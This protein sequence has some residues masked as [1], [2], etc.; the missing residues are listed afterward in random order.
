MDVSPD[1]P[2]PEGDAPAA[3]PGDPPLPPAP[4][5]ATEVTF[6]PSGTMRVVTWA[7]LGLFLA[8]TV[9]FVACAALGA[10]KFLATPLG[11]GI[12]LTPLLAVVS[13]IAGAVSRRV[14]KSLRLEGADLVLEREGSERRVPVASLAEG[15]LSPHEKRV[16]LQD[17]R[18]DV[19]SAA[20]KDDAAG[21]ALLEAAG[22]DA[23]KRTWRTRLGPVDFLTAMSWLVGP[24]VVVPLSEL[25]ATAFHTDRNLGLPL[26]PFLFILQFYLVRAVFGPAH[27]VVGADG[28]IVKQR[29]RKR[30]VPFGELDHITTEVNN[31]TLHLTDGTAIRARARNL[32]DEAR[33]TI[34]ERVGA[35]L[36]LRGGRA[37]EPGA[38]AELDRGARTAAEWRAAL[39]GLLSSDRGYRAAR[40]TRE[41]VLGVLENPAAPA[42]RR[43]GAALALARSA[44]P[45]ADADSTARTRIAASASANERVRVAL[46]KIAAGQLDDAAIDEAAEE[47]EARAD[48]PAPRRR[49][50]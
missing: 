5:G 48:E 34:E 30:F 29:L 16:Y 7:S 45:G 49:I 8:L 17:R 33:A 3:P 23:S 40:L 9:T 31:V 39:S 14:A 41:Q 20:V 50:A 38:L 32:S 4:P 11:W 37:A 36:A 28:I 21:Q 19:Y 15:W 12:F 6:Q 43:I 13:T 22:L 10:P 26:V 1:K 47:D 25:I 2:S 35:A 27:L 24:I 46:E 44:G 18:S 42:A